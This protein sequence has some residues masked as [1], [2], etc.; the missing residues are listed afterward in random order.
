MGNPDV[1]PERTVQYEI[2]YKQ[3]VN[4]DFGFDLTIFYKDI[5]DLLGVEFIDTYT[6]AQYAR[7]TN[8][9]FGNVFGI[10]FA[11][12][13][14][15]LGPVSLAL[16]YTLAAGDRQRQRPPRDRD[17]RRGGRG[18][19]AAA[20][21][22]QLGPA[23][24][25]EHHRRAGQ[26]RQLQVSTVIRVGSG[27]PYTPEIES[28]FGFGL[29]TNSGRKPTGF[30][31]DLR[32]EKTLASRRTG[33]AAACSCASSTCST[34]ATS[35]ARSTPAPAVPTTRAFP[36]TDATPSRIRPGSTRRAAI[37]IGV[38]MGWR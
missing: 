4:D 12:D 34:R 19:A 25:A 2:G 16:D 28:G 20:G 6:G 27:Q 9:D 23:P 18:S 14:R 35:T 17:A 8:V 26:A 10:T 38:R 31:V 11:L 21:A 13:H 3:V 7:L 5:R 30:L 37:E 22:V 36:V 29:E 33:L 24:H 1:K 32:A 15:R